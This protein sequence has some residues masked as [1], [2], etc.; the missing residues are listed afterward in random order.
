MSYFEDKADN[1]YLKN[2]M[3]GHDPTTSI[4]FPAS[5]DEPESMKTLSSFVTSKCEAKEVIE[6]KDL[7]EWFVCSVMGLDTKAS[8][9]EELA[10]FDRDDIFLD[11]FGTA[12]IN[13]VPSQSSA[14]TPHSPQSFSDSIVSLSQLFLD[15]VSQ[16]SSSNCLSE[17][18]NQ[19]FLENL[20]PFVLRHLTRHLIN[21]GTLVPIHEHS[22]MDDVA[23]YIAN[24]YLKIIPNDLSFADAF[25]WMMSREYFLIHFMEDNELVDHRVRLT[26]TARNNQSPQFTIFTKMLTPEIEK[27]KKQ[28][29][30][31]LF[32]EARRITSWR[33][34]LQK[35]ASGEEILNDQSFLKSSVFRS[36]LLSLQEKFQHLASSVEGSESLKL[37]TI[38]HTLLVSPLPPTSASLGLQQALFVNEALIH[39]IAADVDPSEIF[40]SSIFD[41]VDNEILARSLV[42]CHSVCNLVGVFYTNQ[43]P[44]TIETG[45]VRLIN[46]WP[47]IRPTNKRA[48]HFV[49]PR[50]KKSLQR[51]G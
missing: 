34:L 26:D 48:Y 50:K 3:S 28:F 10:D 1:N 21:T 17:R 40:H 42:R 5:L 6:W 51:T 9:Q 4:A 11:Q 36:T 29:D 22:A 41:E 23:S 16:L 18:I 12:R 37:L 47:S 46:G 2:I 14:S 25:Q 13:L 20:F 45:D 43:G 32:E 39:S 44:P 33:E 19:H 35:V 30:P 49:C 8:S 24:G 38:L 27:L 15:L 31:D 7:M